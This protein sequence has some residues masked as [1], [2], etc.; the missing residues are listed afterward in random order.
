MYMLC[1]PCMSTAAN[2]CRHSRSHH[3]ANRHIFFKQHRCRRRGARSRPQ[4]VV[5]GGVQGG[6]KL[7]GDTSKY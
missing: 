7:G 6:D 3:A 4:K 1:M 5:Q 2:T